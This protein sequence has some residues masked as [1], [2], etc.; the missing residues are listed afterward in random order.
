MDSE[1]A[2]TSCF[3]KNFVISENNSR[4][5]SLAVLYLGKTQ[6]EIF[7]DTTVINAVISGCFALAGA[8]IGILASA[9]LTTYRIEQLEKKVDKHNQVIDRVYKLEQH[10]AVIDEEIKVA[11]H[12]IADLEEREVK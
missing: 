8:L 5:K 2:H 10:G 11:N 12:R 9:K 4:T 1:V 7:M 3:L 6:W